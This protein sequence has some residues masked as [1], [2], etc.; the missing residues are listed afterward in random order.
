MIDT[1]Q[2]N[3]M[4][5]KIYSPNV[6]S[7]G[8][9]ELDQSSYSHHSDMDIG[10]AVIDSYTHFVLHY[11]ENINKTSKNTLQDLVRT[12]SLRETLLTSPV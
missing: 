1:C 10:V 7:T 6:I 9:S 8:S 5:S 11:L 12:F 2:A 4:Y 3:T